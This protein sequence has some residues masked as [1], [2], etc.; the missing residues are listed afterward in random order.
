MEADPLEYF[1][2]LGD[3]KSLSEVAESELIETE[4]SPSKKTEHCSLVEFR[5]MLS[6]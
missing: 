6:I 2:V 3:G 5:I 4:M 1:E